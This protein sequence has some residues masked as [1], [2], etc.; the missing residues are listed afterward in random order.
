MHRFPE[1]FTWGVACAAYQCEGA[2]NE[3]GKGPNIWDEYCHDPDLHAV[4]NGDSGDIACDSYHRY[5]EDIALM[6]AHHVQAYRFSISWARILPEGTGRVNPKGLEYYD[7][8]VDMLLENGIEPF[9]FF[10]STRFRSSRITVSPVTLPS[11][12]TVKVLIATFSA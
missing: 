1:N 11:A 7:R 5:P 2:W 6:K 4:K 12:V 9:V 10:S 3:D 8:V